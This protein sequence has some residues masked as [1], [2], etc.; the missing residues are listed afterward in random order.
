MV[1][2]V[3]EKLELMMQ[4]VEPDEISKIERK[5]NLVKTS[6]RRCVARIELKTIVREDVEL[7]VI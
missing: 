3:G 2:I 7:R 4:I 1:M 6:F 5:S